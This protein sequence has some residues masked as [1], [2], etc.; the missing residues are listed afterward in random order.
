MKPLKLG[1]VHLKVRDLE[2]SIKFYQDLLGLKITEKL[3][4]FVFMTDG[5]PHNSLAMQAIGPQ[6]PTPGEHSVGLY[7]AAYEVESEEQCHEAWNRA[8]ALVPNVVAVDH[9]ISWALYLDDP[10]GNGIEIML[11][12]RTNGG[13]AL[14]HG[15]QA[16]LKRA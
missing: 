11:D 4:N 7:R 3:G 10:D 2:R 13:R 16:L 9:G 6:A 5:A 12:R 14:W 1:H 15:S 8:E